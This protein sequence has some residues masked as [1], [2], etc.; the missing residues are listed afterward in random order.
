MRTKNIPAP[1]YIYSPWLLKPLHKKTTCFLRPCSI[2][3]ITSVSAPLFVN[4]DVTRF[5]LSTEITPFF[6][7]IETFGQPFFVITFVEG[8]ACGR[9]H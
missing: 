2:P 7:L 5:M 9:F 1:T 6:A 3:Q 8:I 4:P